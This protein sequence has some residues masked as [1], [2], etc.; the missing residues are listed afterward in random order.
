MPISYHHD[1]STG[2]NILEQ[3][4]YI[5][6]L[7]SELAATFPKNTRKATRTF[8]L[9]SELQALIYFHYIHPVGS[10]FVKITKNYI[11]FVE[12]KN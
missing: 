5:A 11:T 12:S 7:S 4:W 8:G 6:A 3:S 1:K 9:V 2:K 10:A